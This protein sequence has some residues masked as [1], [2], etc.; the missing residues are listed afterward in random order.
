ML[1]NNFFPAG[2]QQMTNFAL[3][4]VLS[5]YVQMTTTNDLH[6]ASEGDDYQ[7]STAE[8]LDENDSSQEPGPGDTVHIGTNVV[9]RTDKN[10]EINEVLLGAWPNPSNLTIEHNVAHLN[11]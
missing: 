7:W 10:I 3:F 6:L 4:I 8:F 5:L 2:N 11:I 1:F 9:L